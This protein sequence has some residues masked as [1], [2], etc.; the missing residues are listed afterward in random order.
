MKK[1]K[2]GYTQGVF[3]MLHIGHINL[4]NNAKKQCDKL[5]VG[6]NSDNLVKQYKDCIPF[7][8]E[9]ER[10]DVVSNIKAVDEC[11]IVDTLD[12]SEVYRHNKFDVI[13]IGDDWKNNPR[14]VKTEKVM[15]KYGVDIVYLPYTK[16]ISSTLLRDY[17][18]RD[19]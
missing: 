19:K 15:G 1:Y 5:I 17:Q 4:L 8:S 13:F 6:V 9:Q 3:D 2:V 7:V 11:F 14:W 16:G 12:K 18:D 10:K